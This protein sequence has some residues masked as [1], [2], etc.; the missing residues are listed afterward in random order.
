MAIREWHGVKVGPGP[1]DLGIRDHLQSLKV[2]LQDPLQNLKVGP[3][4]PLRGLKVG[5]RSPF[6]NEFISFQNISLFFFYLFICVSFLNKIQTNINCEQ[7]KSI[8]N[9]KDKQV[10]LTTKK[11]S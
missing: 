3:K 10:Y 7:Q 2:G 5:P 9:T 4:D 6:F 1:R 11:L 8:V